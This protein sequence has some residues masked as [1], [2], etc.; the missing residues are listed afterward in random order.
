MLGT[1]C[2]Q[3]AHYS[4][5]CT[6]VGLKESSSQLEIR[7]SVSGRKLSGLKSH[8]VSGARRVILLNDISGSMAPQGEQDISIGAVR[9]FAELAP[10]DYQLALINFNDQPHLDIGL[11]SVNEF[12]N[13]FNMPDLQARL[14]PHGATALMDAVIAGL[15]HLAQTGSR[16]GDAIVILSDGLDNA[17][18]VRAS[19]LRRRVAAAHARLFLLTL[20]SATGPGG[21]HSPFDVYEIVSASGGLVA[22]PRAINQWMVDR[23]GDEGMITPKFDPKTI[24][25]KIEW[26]F[27]FVQ[28]AERLD[29]DLDSPVTSP[30]SLKVNMTTTDHKRNSIRYACPATLAP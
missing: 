27:I 3:K 6:V 5:T 28:Q 22:M 9:D 11:G 10:I 14:K 29:F 24:R 13:A 1:T 19:E 8:L 21:S 30:T 2:A 26:I 25:E 18:S 12:R 23:P 15:D 20:R 16:D 7:A 17:S 4:A